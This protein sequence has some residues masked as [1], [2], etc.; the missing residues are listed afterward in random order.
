MVTV[1]AIAGWIEM[2]FRWFARARPATFRPSGGYSLRRRLIATTVGSSV[3][4]GLVSTA[5]VLAIAWK[6]T[7]ETFDDTLEEGAKLVL[8]LGE[9]VAS[10]SPRP[11]PSSGHAVRQG[12][13][14]GLDY[15]I[16]DRNGALLR[17]GEDAPA[18]PFVAPGS[19]DDTFYDTRADGEWWRVYVRRHDTLGFTVQIGQE[20]DER[21]ALLRDGLTSLAWPLVALW[22]AL[23]VVNWWLVRRQ[24]APLEHLAQG[25]AEK[26]PSDL[27]PVPDDSQAREVQ[28]VVV[29]LNRLLERLARALEGERRFTADAAHEL[30]TPLAALASRIQLMQRH[31]TADKV[32]AVA[33]DLQRLREDVRRSTAL[34][35]NLLQLARL[36]P[37]SSDAVAFEAIAVPALLDDVL[38]ACAPAAAARR[39]VVSVACD[40]PTMTGHYDWLF[41]ALRNLLDNA[42]RYGREGGRVVVSARRRGDAIEIAVLDDGPG[43]A[44]DALERLTRRFFRVL[45]TGAQGSGLGLSIAARVAALHGGT[46][47]FGIGLDGRGLG[48]TLTVPVRP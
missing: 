25:M 33:A 37:Q 13:T 38:Q 18:R 9:G 24:L 34:V 46:L 42:V 6:E 32:P 19:A 30:R 17:R 7:N 39:M 28:S 8:A 14:M 4:V 44:A 27:S 3:L 20:W 26:S 40:V 2:A 45:G 41:S 11:A 16:V 10:G 22:L 23:G 47:A 15:Q 48:A 5:I 31:Y 12:P 36:D 21:N 35:E 43:V 1:P 29:A